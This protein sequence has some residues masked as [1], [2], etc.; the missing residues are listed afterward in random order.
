MDTFPT[1]VSRH[2]FARRQHTPSYGARQSIHLDL[3]LGGKLQNLRTIKNAEK[4]DID[5]A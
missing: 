1:T 3:T 5:G 4:Y 2:M